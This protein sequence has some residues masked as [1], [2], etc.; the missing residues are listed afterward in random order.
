M[1]KFFPRLS[2]IDKVAVSI[3]M[4]VQ[5]LFF[6]C[7]YRFELFPSSIS[8]RGEIDSKILRA[9][10]LRIRLF[11]SFRLIRKVS[12]SI[13]QPLFPTTFRL[14]FLYVCFFIC[15]YFV[16][17]IFT[18]CVCRGFFFFFYIFDFYY[19]DSAFTSVLRWALRCLHLA[20][21][22]TFCFVLFPHR[23]ASVVLSAK[24]DCSVYLYRF[25]SAI[26]SLF[27]SFI[28]S[29]VLFSFFFFLLFF[30]SFCK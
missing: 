13:L 11:Y 21:S 24:H 29:R 28:H 25:A 20:L 7:S 26:L 16:P 10:L 9:G 23:T 15:F 1:C 19:L 8:R 18:A 4:E 3:V 2:I 14:I 6:V 5:A 30:F 12:L 17:E 27:F 22:M